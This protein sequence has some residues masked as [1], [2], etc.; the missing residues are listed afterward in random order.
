M[1]THIWYMGTQ[2]QAG[3][4]N[5]GVLSTPQISSHLKMMEDDQKCQRSGQTTNANLASSVQILYLFL[6]LWIILGKT[7]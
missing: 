4:R 7:S 2:P 6:I 3:P 1:F 5:E